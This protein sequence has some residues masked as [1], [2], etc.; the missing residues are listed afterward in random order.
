MVEHLTQK[1]SN[2]KRQRQQQA[3]AVQERLQQAKSLGNAGWQRKESA[4]S[5]VTRESLIVPTKQE[6][7]QVFDRI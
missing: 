2:T 5:P 4:V 3:Q 1:L 7:R 6:R